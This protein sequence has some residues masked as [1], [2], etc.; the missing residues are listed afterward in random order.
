MCVCDNF[1]LYTGYISFFLFKRYTCRN[2]VAY[3]F[4]VVNFQFSI[5]NLSYF[6]MRDD[7]LFDYF[8]A[9]STFDRRLLLHLWKEE[10][11]PRVSR[12]PSNVISTFPVAWLR[13]SEST[14]NFRSKGSIKMAYLQKIIINCTRL[15][16]TDYYTQK[17]SSLV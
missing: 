1:A 4:L 17:F 16:F 7:A 12:S 10:T 14:S 15:F 6:Q 8:A 3:L 13:I 11:A 9:S 2:F 5:S